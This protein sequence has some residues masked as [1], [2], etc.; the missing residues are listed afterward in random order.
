MPKAFKLPKKLFDAHNHVWG[1]DD[2]S[3]LVARMDELNIETTLVMG[4]PTQFQMRNE[5]M[6][7]AVKRFRGRLIGGAYYDPRK[8]KK[9]VDE[10]KRYA[11]EGL[12]IVKLFPNLGWMP[13]DPKFGRF[14]DAVAD[15][16]MGVLSHN[17]WLGGSSADMVR[18]PWA[19]YYA[20][21]GKFE[22]VVRMHPE[23]PF[24]MAH[25][26]GIPGVLESVMLTTRTPNLY[27]DC[28]P[29]QGLWAIEK[30]GAVAGSVPP[31]KMLW[32]ADCRPTKEF[33]ER[34]RKALVAIGYGEHL[35]KIFYSNARGIFEKLGMVS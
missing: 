5:S 33:L 14:F 22:K 6:A 13:D 27:V 7:R 34:Y 12:K 1:D 8:G 19:T 2:G 35:D 9:A 29:G 25:M 18:E 11:G 23:T 17:G 31:E 26:G 20:T 16:G 21:P 10:L 15:L 3:K 28:S 4:T 24:I 32:G 30:C